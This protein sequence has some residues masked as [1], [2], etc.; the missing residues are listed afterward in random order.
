[1]N[2]SQRPSSAF[3]DGM[4][5]MGT[6]LTTPVGKALVRLEAAIHT[7]ISEHISLIGK[8]EWL[9]RDCKRAVEMLRQP[10]A[11][12][13]SGVVQGSGSTIDKMCAD[14]YVLARQMDD[15]CEIIGLD[16]PQMWEYVDGEL[17]YKIAKRDERNN[18]GA[19]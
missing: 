1:M 19:N 7:Y 3:L 5:S 17:A 10:M 6:D 9:Q 4:I 15:L 13:S 2:I 11:L 8:L 12:Y 18:K 16:R 14:Q